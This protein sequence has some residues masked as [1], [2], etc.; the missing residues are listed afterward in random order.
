MA[1]KSIPIGG[2]YERKTTM[3]AFLGILPILNKSYLAFVDTCEKVCTI[4][5]KDIFEVKE[6]IFIPLE[7]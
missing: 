5:G 2:N 7:R 6:V 3:S 4:E 1:A